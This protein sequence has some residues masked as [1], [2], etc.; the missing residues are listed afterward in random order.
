MDDLVCYCNGKFMKE[1]EVRVPLWDRGFFGE[2]VFEASRT[3][4]HEPFKWVEHVERLYRSLAYV[5]IDPGLTPQQMME[6]SLT[7]FR[8]NEHFLS[9]ADDYSL[10][11]RI[12]R[13]QAY[14][15]PATGP[16]VLVNC[17]DLHYEDMARM[18]REGVHLVVVSTRQVPS[19]CIDPKAKV[20]NRM[21]QRLAT[22]EAQMVAPNAMPVLL[23][24]DGFCT[25]GATYNVFMVS[26]DRLFTPSRDKILTGIT[27]TTIFGLARELG[28]ECYEADLSVADLTGADEIFITATSYAIGPVSKFNN[29]PVKKPFPGPVTQKLIAG[30]SRMVGIDIVDQCVSH[31]KK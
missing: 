31:G 16:T 24:M 22:L 8:Q 4:H 30:W 25:E 13:G 11:H 28:I 9:S 23:D 3:Y 29:R 17:A 10:V 2:G 12:T 21:H 5:Q 15:A 26:K 19:Q 6:I 1:S 14:W 20:M 7:V 18:Y 27:R